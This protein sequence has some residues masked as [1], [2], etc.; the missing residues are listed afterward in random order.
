M[1]KILLIFCVLS[2]LT[3]CEIQYDGETKLVVTG[4]LMDENGN[5]LPEK[6]IEVTVEGGG[7]LLSPGDDLISYG[8]SDQNGNFTLIFPSPRDGN[9]IYISI[10]NL[11]NQPNEFQVKEI[12]ANKNNF[13]NYKLDLKNITLYNKESITTLSLILNQT[14][15]NKQL[16]D[17]QI[18][19]KQ[20]NS[21]LFLNPLPNNSDYLVNFYNVIKNQTIVLKYTVVDYSNAAT[22]IKYSI[23]IPIINDAVTYTITY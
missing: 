5:S 7:F 10:N 6:D 17:I 15:T 18:E 13:E 23:S 19:G 4:K 20:P 11:I 14:S 21:V 2:F 3:S 22:P 1:K 16:K 8:K 12:T 9:S